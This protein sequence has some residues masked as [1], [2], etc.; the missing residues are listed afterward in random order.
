VERRVAITG[1]PADTDLS[2][3][4]GQGFAPVRVPE[5]GVALSDMLARILQVRTG[6]LVEIELLERDRRKIEV[7]VTAVIQGFLG[8][9]AYMD[10]EAA[11]ALLREGAMI[12]GTHIAFDE[13]HRDNLFK[14]LKSTPIANF[15]ALQRMSLQQFRDTMARNI[16]W[17]ISVYVTLAVIIAFGVVFNFARIS[18]SEQGREMA[19]L[20]VL[21]FT[22]AEV[23]GLLLTELAILTVVAQPLGWVLGYGFAYAVARGFESELYRVPL[24][25]EPYVFATAS[26]VVI[27]AAVL[28]GFVVR[29]RID[30]LDLVEVLKTRE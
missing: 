2:R 1:K 27:G 24:I 3:V 11:N 22:R 30:R 21:G 23:S 8:L 19:S 28:S 12:S 18:L 6:D 29:R 7:P 4:L 9:T 14:A 16:L 13:L 20:R 26:L 17:M 25:V 15:V 10:L 5:A